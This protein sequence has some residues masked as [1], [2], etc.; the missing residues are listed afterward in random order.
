[1]WVMRNYDLTEEKARGIK[2]ELDARK[3]GE[4]LQTA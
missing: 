2:A 4:L 1:M 3:N